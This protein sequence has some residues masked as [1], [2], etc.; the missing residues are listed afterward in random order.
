MILHTVGKYD[1]AINTF[2]KVL[3]LD[4]GYADAWYEKARCKIKKND[5]RGC[6]TDLKKTI[7]TARDYY[8]DPAHYAKLALEEKDFEGLR[9]EE[10]FKEIT[11]LKA[12]RDSVANTL[13][14]VVH[15]LQI[16]PKSSN[17]FE[18]YYVQRNDTKNILAELRQSI[19][20]R[21]Y[22]KVFLIGPTGSGIT[23]ELY[24]LAFDLQT[25][26]S[27]D[28]LILFM[29]IFDNTELHTVSLADIIFSITRGLVK[30]AA[31]LSIP[32]EDEVVLKL[33]QWFVIAER[34]RTNQDTDRREE[35]LSSSLEIV[36]QFTSN[37][38]PAEKYGED[39]VLQLMRLAT[40][41]FN[42]VIASVEKSIQKRVV[43][44]IDDLN[45]DQDFESIED[46][47]AN[48]RHLTRLRSWI[49][50]NAPYLAIYSK[51]FVS[52]MKSLRFDFY[53][54]PIFNVRNPDGSE[55]LE[56]IKVMKEIARRRISRILIPDQVVERAA[57]SS[58]GV[59]AE[60]LGLLRDCSIK[61]LAMKRP[62]VNLNILNEVAREKIDLAHKMMDDKKYSDKL[63]K[64]LEGKITTSEIANDSDLLRLLSQGIIL[65]YRDNDRIWYDIHPLFARLIGK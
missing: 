14:D 43:M 8:K 57:K 3:A 54:L 18:Y 33:K 25:E 4:A 44:I 2:E 11:T 9:N 27:N 12:S 63:V 5:V 51:N 48:I 34:G 21:E 60:F 58:G 35:L 38:Y 10:E 52:E 24:R 62:S 30:N 32:F 47:V 16:D 28:M 46:F 19:L 65:E 13:E 17:F 1:E 49:V 59:V 23:T 37:N 20:H 42:S 31:E 36:N 53:Q 40:D 61:A 15:T 39:K 29:S 26:T 50:L 64:V 7:Q 6:L 22:A 41:I 56:G 45:K 55:N